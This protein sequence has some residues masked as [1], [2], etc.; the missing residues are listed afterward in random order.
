MSF[1]D[2]DLTDT[3]DLNVKVEEKAEVEDIT[4]DVKEEVNIDDVINSIDEITEE[5]HLT[6]CNY[7]F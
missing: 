1:A 6:E 3:D 5:A 4:D 7:R 2:P